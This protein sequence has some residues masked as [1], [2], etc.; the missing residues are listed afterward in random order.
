MS[1]ITG[2]LQGFCEEIRRRLKSELGRFYT[3]GYMSRHLPQTWVFKTES[4][5]FTMIMD[6]GGDVILT[7]VA[8]RSPDVTVLTTDLVLSEALQYNSKPKWQ[9]HVTF[10]TRKGEAAYTYMRGKFGLWG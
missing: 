5:T 7:G 4:E 3:D 6:R 10:N 2:P 8:S 9:W 1:S